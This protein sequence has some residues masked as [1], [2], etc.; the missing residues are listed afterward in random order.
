[1]FKKSESA[2]VGD[3]KHSNP[4]PAHMDS[5]PAKHGFGDKKSAPALLGA[6]IRIKG[7]LSGDEDLI[8]QGHVEGTIELKQN[9]LT[10]GAQGFVKASSRART[11]TVE[12]KVEGDLI[13]DER[14]VVKSSGDVRGNIVAPRVTLE[15]GAKFKG[16]I[17]MES[18]AAKNNGTGQ[19][20]RSGK[21]SDGAA[22]SNAARKDGAQ[23]AGVQAKTA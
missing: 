9:N 17:D 20:S 22:N 3:Y 18:K 10:I 1:M 21:P 7:E 6:S 4:E 2:D 15:D 13:G 14:I 8:I 12:G 19:E 16:S 23:L 5:A 11:I